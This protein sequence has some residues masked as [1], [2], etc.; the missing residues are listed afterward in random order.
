MRKKIDK[1]I[2]ILIENSIKAHHRG[3]IVLIGDRSR[4]QIINLYNLWLSI[5]NK[6]D[7]TIL[8]PKILWCFNKNLGFTSHQQKRHKEITK[9]LKQ[10]LYEKETENPF[11]NFLSQTEIRY[12][13]YKETKNILGSNF[14]LLVLQDFEAITPNILCQTIETVIGGGLVFLILKSM[15]SLKKMYSMTMDVHSRFR[16]DAFSEV[17][18]LFNERMILS[19]ASNESVIFVDDELNLLQISEKQESLRFIEEDSEILSIL[20]TSEENHKKLIRS[21]ESNKVIFNL[22]KTTKTLDQAKVVLLFLDSIRNKKI[23]FSEK[24]ETCFLSASR[25]RGKSAALGLAIA[26]A[27]MFNTH[28][29]FVSA[30]T[31]EN[32]KT[33]FEFIEK[34]LESL[35]F[36]KNLDFILKLDKNENPL[37]LT[38]FTSLEGEE[39]RIQKQRVIYIKPGEKVQNCDLLVIDEAAAIPINKIKPMI[40][41][42]N[43]TIFISSTIHGYEGTGRSL[44]IKLVEEMRKNTKKNVGRRYLRESKM[45]IPIRYNVSDPIENWLTKLLCLNCTI[46]EKLKNSL[47]HPKECSLYMLN[48]ETLFSYNKS[49]EGFLKKIWSLFVSSHYKNSP[50]DL[51]LL[52]DAPAHC[53]AVLLGPLNVK[54]NKSGLPDVLV[55]I[56]FCFEGKVNR[57]TVND[58]K[59]RGIK[60]SGDLIPWT[61]SEQYLNKSIFDCLGVRVVRIAT[62]KNSK[63]L[64]YG[65]RALGLLEDFFRGKMN[66]E[67][68]VPFLEFLNFNSERAFEGID[69]KVKPK[70]KLLPL[71]K[72]IEE[73]EPPKISYLSVAFGLSKNLFRY[74]KKN[75]FKTFYIRHVKNETTGEHSCMMIKSL[76]NSN[77][78]FEFFFE[79]YKKRF[80]KLLKSD[81][82][83]LDLTIAFDI[84]DPNL[85]IK[86]NVES[87]EKKNLKT[88]F[89]LYFSENDLQRLTAYGK[90]QI[91]HYIIKDLIL[92]ISD[93][94]FAEKFP[95]EAKLSFSQALILLGFG[96]QNRDLNNI[97]EILKIN[98]SQILALYNKSIKRLTKYIKIDFDKKFENKLGFGNKKNKNTL[99]PL[100]TDSDQIIGKLN[101]K[102][103]AKN[104]K[105]KK[106]KK[107]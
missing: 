95:N 28:S 63:R 43:S 72:K 14:N 40:D 39:K 50:N 13:Y 38:F 66:V 86:K 36:K 85:T 97:A 34:G 52:S 79:Q 106:F 6:K 59:N 25:G 22:L 67:G 4:D 81:F 83:D 84:L 19:L 58:N 21:L 69:S 24:N 42:C 29:I 30:A 23:A 12:C 56:Q 74:W 68:S 49:S 10:G 3:M 8:K 104:L 44:S 32:L 64:G 57:Q 26:G 55:A 7:Q 33:V 11:E 5:K 1:K 53:L 62:H 65:T 17:N 47:P 92:D 70:K 91:E 48:K 89:D 35:D 90:N 71:L 20:K 102:F 41:N 16:T 51:Q 45:E 99:E 80:V 73:I 101:S 46:S 54:N 76:D 31:P 103:A 98:H 37:S 78:N 27:L 2:R 77:L 18:P 75:N 105:K 15:D 96:V 61:F 60:P 107:N 93:L 87:E 9:R 82:I 94:F 100:K 88:N